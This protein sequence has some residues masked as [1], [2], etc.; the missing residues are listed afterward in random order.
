P[1]PVPPPR[2]SLLASRVTSRFVLKK[3]ALCSLSSSLSIA[4]SLFA[5]CARA[6]LCGCG[7]LDSDDDRFCPRSGLRLLN[8][9]LCRRSWLGLGL[10]QHRWVRCRPPQLL[11]LP[12]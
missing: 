2:H 4:L 9:R 10:P 1:P 5:T 7:D 8:D 12:S 11:Q 3:W 6:L